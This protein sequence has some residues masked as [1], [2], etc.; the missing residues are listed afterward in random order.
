MQTIGSTSWPNRHQRAFQRLAA[1]LS[2][3]SGKPIVL[4]VGPG[5]ATRVMRPFL[6]NGATPRSGPGRL[7]TDLAR[8]ADQLLR[9]L[10]W[11]RLV[12]LEPAELRAALDR[13]AHWMVVDRSP[14][15]LRAVADDIPDAEFLEIDIARQAIPR[16]ADV[17]V[18]FNVIPRT[19]DPPAAMR[20]VAAA[21]RPGGYLLVDD[22][23]AGR[24]LPGPPEFEKVDEKLYRR[25]PA[26][27]G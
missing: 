3:M 6:A 24:W 26:A 25:L 12:S 17:V 27:P 14:R 7:L 20:H 8:F 18:A 10:P 22:R 2:A 13:P 9:R 5:A 21:V 23:S 11:M 1:H 4:I 15:V 19:D 16:Q